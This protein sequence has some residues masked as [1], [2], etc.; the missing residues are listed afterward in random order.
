MSMTPP[1]PQPADPSRAFLPREGG[2]AGLLGWLCLALVVYA[3]LYPF[4]GWRD[5]GVKPWDF[6]VLPWPRYWTGFDLVSNFVG[7]MPLGLLWALARAR[8]GLRLRWAIS[9]AWLG[10]TLLSLTLETI[11]NYLPLRVASNVDLALNSSGALVGAWLLWP[12]LKVRGLLAF[13]HWRRRWFDHRGA[14]LLLAMWPAALSLPQPIPF[15]L[16]QFVEPGLQFLRRLVAHTPLEAHIDP[17]V[18]FHQPLTPMAEIWC[19]SLGVLAPCLVAF[20]AMPR[21]WRRVVLVLSVFGIAMAAQWLFTS[22]N[23]GPEHPLAWMTP[24]SKPGLVAGLVLALAAAWLPKPAAA[25]CGLMLISAWVSLVNQAPGDPYFDVQLRAWEQGEFIRFFGVSRW[26]AWIWPLAALG[27]LLWRVVQPTRDWAMSTLDP[28]SGLSSRWLETQG[29]A[30]RLPA[31]S[32]EGQGPPDP[33]R[34]P[35]PG[36]G[37]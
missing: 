33:E 17:Y 10:A 22:L 7:Y 29:A 12:V 8:R 2:S 14:I 9:G 32:P 36:H 1:R 18:V 13:H 37:A 23:Y 31:A 28:S 25:A 24:A 15:A 6:L 21:T 27:F 26:L 30:S 35:E 3:T 16:G 20:S 4:S 19:V 11:Q 5:T 34:R